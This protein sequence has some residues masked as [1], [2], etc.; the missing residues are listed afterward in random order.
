PAHLD[1]GEI[2]R[3]LSRL[4]GVSN[5]HDLHVWHMGS[6][7]VALSAHVAIGESRDW[8]RTLGTAQRMLR[9]R[10]G[11][12]HVTLQP[13]WAVNAPAG[14]KVIPVKSRE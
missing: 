13:D 4:P 7:D 9:E 8:P 5:V 10:F 14:R 11:I 3:E 12:T 1:Y 2:G 6:E